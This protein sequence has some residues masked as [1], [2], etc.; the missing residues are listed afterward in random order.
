MIRRTKKLARNLRD[1]IGQQ[2]HRFKA[3]PV[4][5]SFRNRNARRL[6]LRNRPALSVEEKRIVKSLNENG[7]AV[8]HISKLFP[9]SVFGELQTYASKRWKEEKGKGYIQNQINR[10]EKHAASSGEGKFGKAKT[11]KYFL[12]NLWSSAERILDI[13]HSFTRF[14]VSEPILNVVNSYLGMFSK[15][16]GWH[17]QTTVPVPDSN[18]Y[19]SQ[20]WHRDP[21]DRKLVKVFLY[22]NDVDDGAGPFCYLYKSN[23]NNKWGHLFKQEPPRGNP[24]LPPNEDDFI[25]Q[26]D[27]RYLPGKAGTL[28]FCDTSGFHKGG[29]ATSNVRIMYTS[30]FTSS[31][32]PWRIAYSYPPNFNNTLKTPAARYAVENDPFQK[33]PRYYKKGRIRKQ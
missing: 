8:T 4:V 14:S 25:P 7:I 6:F 13:R 30:I 5:W 3:H 15:F 2:Y 9:E 1:T 17:L 10:K 21:E 19:A 24:F 32:A 33:E 18:P 11:S 26:E 12:V 20:K 28:I 23:Q 31:A 22:L 29:N 27:V 16:R